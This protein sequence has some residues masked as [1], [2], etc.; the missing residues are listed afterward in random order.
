M[1][2]QGRVAPDGARRRRGASSRGCARGGCRRSGSTSRSCRRPARRA[3][4]AARRGCGRTRGR[5]RTAIHRDPVPRTTSQTESGRLPSC[6]PTPPL[7]TSAQRP[8]PARSA[9]QKQKACAPDSR[10]SRPCDRQSWRGSTRASAGSAPR[11]AIQ[12]RRTTVPVIA[13]EQFHVPE[14]H[15][16]AKLQPHDGRRRGRERDG[17]APGLHVRADLDSARLPDAGRRLGQRHTPVLLE[18][19]GDKVGRPKDGARSAEPAPPRCVDAA[20]RPSPEDEVRPTATAAVEEAT[21]CEQN[22]RRSMAAEDSRC[23]SG[24]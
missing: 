4:A 11:P 19:C 24:S 23:R 21:R 17:Q 10:R 20:I 8:I 13:E 16:P 3:G 15:V 22:V 5:R 9:F 12:G 18:E 2:L 7:R 1:T 6:T 14:A